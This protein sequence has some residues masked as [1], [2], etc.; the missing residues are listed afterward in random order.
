MELAL[1][2]FHQNDHKAN[3]FDADINA[4]KVRAQDNDLA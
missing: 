2:I 3:N 4:N 1:T